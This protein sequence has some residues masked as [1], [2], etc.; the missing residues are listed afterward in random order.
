MNGRWLLLLVML[1][2]GSTISPS[3]AQDDP[4]PASRPHRHQQLDRWCRRTR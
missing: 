3:L 4:R 2:F 1:G